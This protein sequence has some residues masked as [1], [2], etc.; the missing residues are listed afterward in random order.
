MTLQEEKV[1][2]LFLRLIGKVQRHHPGSENEELSKAINLILNAYSN[3]EE[4]IERQ[5]T[6]F[7]DVV[8][9]INCHA[10]KL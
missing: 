9:L 2:E 4:I 8:S 1:F 3:K 5:Q 10:A 7:K 6:V